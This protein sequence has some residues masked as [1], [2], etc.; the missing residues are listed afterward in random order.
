MADERKLLDYAS[1]RRVLKDWPGI[2][3]GFAI[4][5]ACVVTIWV[6]IIIYVSLT[7]GWD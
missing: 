5:V 7:T 1:E 3:I 2:A 4:A 6:S